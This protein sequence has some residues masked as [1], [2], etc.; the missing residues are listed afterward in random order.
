MHLWINHTGQ[1]SQ[2]SSVNLTV[3]VGV[4][5][6][7]VTVRNVRGYLNNLPVTNL[8]IAHQKIAVGQ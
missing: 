3:G 1:Q 6:G 4:H 7:N 2:A 5:L 8:H